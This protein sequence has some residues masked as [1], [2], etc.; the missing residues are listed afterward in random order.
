M[1]TRSL[2]VGIG[3]QT[4]ALTVAQ[5]MHSTHRPDGV[6]MLA[7]IAARPPTADIVYFNKKYVV[8]C[9]VPW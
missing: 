5:L 4:N 7:A 3:E 1:I 2:C 8:A 6:G 9:V